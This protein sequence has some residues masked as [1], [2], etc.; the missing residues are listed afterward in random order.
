[1]TSWPGQRDRSSAMSSQSTAGSKQRAGA[2][3]GHPGR[4]PKFAKSMAALRSIRTQ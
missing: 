4:P 1:M 2:L 3:D